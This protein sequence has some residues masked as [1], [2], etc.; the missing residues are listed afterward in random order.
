ML[1]VCFSLGIDSR[2][3]QDDRYL[4]EAGSSGNKHE[5]L[6]S[7]QSLPRRHK[8]VSGWSELLLLDPEDRIQQK[9][10]SKLCQE[11]VSGYD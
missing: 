8:P 7:L 3:A 1:N 11:S 10:F 6:R 2:G 9:Y 5:R 4:A